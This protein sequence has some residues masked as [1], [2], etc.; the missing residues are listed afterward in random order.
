MYPQ[1]QWM[2]SGG[3]ILYQERR[4]ACDSRGDDSVDMNALAERVRGC[5]AGIACGDA[6][7]VPFV[8]YSA[9][10][11]RKVYGHWRVSDPLPDPIPATPD[12]TPWATYEVT[13]DTVQAFTVARLLAKHRGPTSPDLIEALCELP[14]RYRKPG[15]GLGT[16]RARLYESIAP[17]S[18]SAALGAGAATR[19]MPIALFYSRL[20]TDV[21]FEEA[22]RHASLTHWS[23]PTLACVAAVVALVVEGARA[24]CGPSRVRGLNAAI[25]RVARDPSSPALAVQ[26]LLD[27]AVALG[28]DYAKECRTDLGSNWGFVATEAVP[29]AIGILA[30]QGEEVDAGQAIETAAHIGGDADTIGAIVGGIAGVWAPRTV[31]AEL[32]RQVELRNGLYLDTLVASFTA[33]M[34][35]SA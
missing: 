2:I 32:I 33:A 13:D 30:H 25:T 1:T 35:C 34:P 14:P 5:F 29:T 28:P 24:S 22:I 17:G 9:D 12:R 27:R 31:P 21:V 19:S 7:G 23:K 20:S 15:S 16:L 18:A 6:V 3:S 26:P 4:D 8:G 11:A 10:A